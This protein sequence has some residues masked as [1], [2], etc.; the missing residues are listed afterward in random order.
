MTPERLLELL[1][2]FRTRRIAV[3]GD[4]FLDK[5]LEVDPKL[6]E[7]SLE[8]GKTAHQ[9][10]EIRK[11]PG[12]AGTVVNNLAAL[13][14]GTLHTLGV[15]GDDGEGYDLRREL[16]R[17]G[18]DTSGLIQS[19]EVYTP[20]Y[21]KP[22]DLGVAGLVGEH[23]RYDTKNRHPLNSEFSAKLTAKLDHL[24]PQLDAV[25][26]MDQV[27]MED[28][29]VVSKV[30][31]AALNQLAERHPQ[32]IFWADSRR[33]IHEYRRMV[34]KPNQF[35][36]VGRI[37]ALPGEE[38][39]I[40][41][42]EAALQRLRGETGTTVFVTRGERGML[43][44]DPEIQLVPGVMVP[45]PIDPTGAGDS[46]T[47]G[48]V[49]TLASGGTPAEAALIGNLVASITVQQLGTTGTASPDEVVKRLD[50]WRRQNAVR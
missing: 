30:F 33:F 18:C 27:E 43:V 6:A 22:R 23:S 3:I 49:L 44:S 17:L 13:K 15:I 1:S 14:T 50:I 35:E 16:E 10:V 39:E 41:E 2:K 38:V 31:R 8:T 21:L 45:A 25:V 26:I 12:A 24:L 42:L 28:C 47:A 34:I 48:A 46:A 9:V 5:Y 4:Y 37:N 40:K 29:G 20:T 7:P 19:E 11:S 36:A 32:I